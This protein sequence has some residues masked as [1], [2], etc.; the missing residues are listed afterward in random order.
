[1]PCCFKTKWIIKGHGPSSRKQT[2]CS[3]FY[4]SGYRYAG[5][6]L[7]S[8]IRRH[9]AAAQKVGSGSSCGPTNDPDL[10]SRPFQ[11]SW[12]RPF[13]QTFGMILYMGELMSGLVMVH[14]FWFPAPQLFTLPR[15]QA[16]NCCKA[17]LPGCQ[18]V[19]QPSCTCCSAKLSNCNRWMA[20]L[21]INQA[22]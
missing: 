20:R 3:D 17:T 12:S 22:V 2:F 21:S 10:W 14:V 1:M 16:T 7:I 19:K 11:G 18:A 15:S 4:A 5:T 6:P 13:I 9:L 8:H